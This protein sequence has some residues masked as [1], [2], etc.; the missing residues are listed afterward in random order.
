MGVVVGHIYYFFTDVYPPLHNG[1]RPLGPPQ[2]WR[3]L[4]EGPERN[5]DTVGDV[6]NEIA[7]LGAEVAH[8][9]VR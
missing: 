6:D 2:W 1:S 7:A 3:R 8:P 9:E 4:F 5:D